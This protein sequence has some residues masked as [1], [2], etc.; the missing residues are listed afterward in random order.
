MRLRYVRSNSPMVTLQNT[1]SIYRHIR[2][3][4]R[5]LF[6]LTI[7][8]ISIGD[9]FRFLHS[10]FITS[11]KHSVLFLPTVFLEGNLKRFFLECEYILNIL[12]VCYHV[13]GGWRCLKFTHG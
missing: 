11:I 9:I 3:W 5:S 12:D 10:V 13:I 8:I 7:A 6:I 1:A 4:V 2:S